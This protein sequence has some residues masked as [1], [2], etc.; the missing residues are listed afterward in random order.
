[1]SIKS[2]IYI[3]GVVGFG[4]TLICGVI[5]IVLSLK[6]PRENALRKNFY[7]SLFSKNL[8]EEENKAVTF[9]KLFFLILVLYL[10]SFFILAKE[11]QGQLENQLLEL[12][13]QQ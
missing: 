11:H 12:K 13:S 5:C 6:L 8:T 9:F 2:L 1:M 4:I 7:G 10:G 3:L